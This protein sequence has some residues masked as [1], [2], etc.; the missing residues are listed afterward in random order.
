MEHLNQAIRSLRVAPTDSRA[1]VDVGPLT[2]PAARNRTL[3]YPEAGVKECAELATGG[4]QVVLTGQTNGFFVGP[5]ILDQVKPGMTIAEDAIFG[6]VLSVRRARTSEEAL[7]E[8]NQSPDGNGA[9]IF[10][11]DG[12]PLPSLPAR[13]A[14]A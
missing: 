6:P 9:V 2:D 4:R 8:A 11:R 7:A 1:A 13:S 10:A 14:V 5:S 3:G 12:V